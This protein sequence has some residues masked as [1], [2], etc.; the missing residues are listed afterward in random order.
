MIALGCVVLAQ[1]VWVAGASAGVQ[2]VDTRVTIKDECSFACRTPATQRNYTV[3]FFGKVKSDESPCVAKRK[4]SLLRKG[5]PG[6]GFLKIDSTKSDGD[7]DWEIIRS[8]KPGFT[9]YMVKVKEVRKAT[10]RCLGAKSD[11][12][13]HDPPIRGI[14]RG[15]ELAQRLA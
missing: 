10:L 4:V 7:G 9:Q 8:D 2:K 6:E 11:K 12:E 15:G 14:A 5:K 13:S 1:G 3:T